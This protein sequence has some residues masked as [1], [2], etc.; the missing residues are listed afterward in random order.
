MRTDTFQLNGATITVAPETGASYLDKALVEIALGIYDA[1]TTARDRFQRSYFASAYAQ[2]KVEGT[3]GFDWP[4]DPSDETAMQA[5]CASWLA[6]PGEGVARWIRALNTV[7]ESP[8]DPDL[9]PP[10]KVSQKKGK[11]KASA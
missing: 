5:A 11:A 6:L 8:N 3:L 9:K 7:N 1:G 2:S 10:D 4:A